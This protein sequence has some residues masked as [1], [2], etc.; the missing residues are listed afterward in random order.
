MHS[1]CMQA[2]SHNNLWYQIVELSWKTISRKLLEYSLKI[3]NGQLSKQSNRQQQKKPK[4]TVQP[5]NE[6]RPQHESTKGNVFAMKRR[7]V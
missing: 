6:Y 1:K 7:K 2:S 3:L 5:T 4:H